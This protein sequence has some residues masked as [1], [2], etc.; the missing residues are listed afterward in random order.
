MKILWGYYSGMSGA[1]F[2]KGGTYVNGDKAIGGAKRIGIRIINRA[3]L[4]GL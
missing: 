4:F 3:C 1:T 2:L